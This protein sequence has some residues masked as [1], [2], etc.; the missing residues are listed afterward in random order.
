MTGARRV[1]G[2]LPDHLLVNLKLKVW[3]DVEVVPKDFIIVP[4]GPQMSLGY[5]GDRS[6]GRMRDGT[7]LRNPKE[8]CHR[9]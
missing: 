5:E 9:V 1:R 3:V 2:P 8:R 7:V 6:L 4:N